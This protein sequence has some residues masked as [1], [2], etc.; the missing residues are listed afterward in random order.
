MADRVPPLAECIGDWIV[1]ATK[2]DVAS[3]KRTV[4]MWE[5]RHKLAGLLASG[6]ALSG[7]SAIALAK[8]RAIRFWP[9]LAEYWGEV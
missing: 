4:W 6:P 5:F 2:H 9:S 3:I 8:E 1:T 7:E